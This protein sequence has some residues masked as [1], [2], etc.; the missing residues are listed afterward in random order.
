M[1]NLEE[2]FLDTLGDQMAK[3]YIRRSKSIEDSSDRR[4]S[5]QVKYLH[6]DDDE[7]EESPYSSE[8]EDRDD[9]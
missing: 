1:S 7:G 6:Q 8:E 3:K 2:S 4:P 9:Y 5:L